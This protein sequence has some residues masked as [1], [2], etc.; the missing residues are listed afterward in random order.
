MAQTLANIAIKAFTFSSK[1]MYSYFLCTLIDKHEIISNAPFLR[2]F[3]MIKKVAIVSTEMPVMDAL[4]L[5]FTGKYS[6]FR[7]VIF[8]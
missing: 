1:R 4:I 2:H 5:F 8:L 6:S 7:L 3:L